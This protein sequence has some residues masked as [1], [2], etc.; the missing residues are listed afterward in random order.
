MHDSFNE[1]N[2]IDEDQ[3][4]T[5]FRDVTLLALSG[6]VAIVLL[7]LPWLNLKTKQELIKE[8]AG[9]V[10][11]E[12]FWPKDIDADKISTIAS[13][14]KRSLFWL[15]TRYWL[16]SA[17]IKKVVESNWIKGISSISL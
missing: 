11:I 15:K 3:S 6:F 10:I 7:L 12:L 9:S 8:P 17:E 16:P 4:N 13:R 2:A 1:L 14:W 5:V